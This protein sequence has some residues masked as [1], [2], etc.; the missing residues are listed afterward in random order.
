MK[1][2]SEMSWN[3]DGSDCSG[4]ALQLIPDEIPD[5]IKTL[6]FSFNFLPTLYNSTFQRLRNLVSLDLTR[7]SINF[8]YDDVFRYQFDLETLI[9]VANPLSFISDRAFSGPL[10]I[11]YLGLAGS[12]INS[13][14]DIPTDHL[15][16]LETLDLRGSDLH[17]L[18]G[19]LKL[20]RQQLKR[21][22]FDLNLIEN[23]RAADMETLRGTRDLEVSFKGNN[24]V[25]V[26][27][28]AFQNLDLGS[29][30]F[31]GCFDK[32]HISIL[33]KGLEGV[34][35]N[36]LHFG[37]FEDSSKG[38]IMPSDLQF[39]CNI[40][41]IDVSFQ[42]QYFPG[43]TN[44]SF[45]CFAEIQ[46]LDFTRAHLSR[47]PSNLSN[48]SML[49]HLILDMNSFTSV[50]D[51][52]PMN[53]PSLTHLSVSRN[54]EYLH[55][56]DNC[57]EPLS[58]LVELQLSHSNLMTGDVCCN[59]QL[60]GLR[61]LKLLNLSY[62]FLM[63]WE[64]LPFNATPNLE[65]LDC[66]KTQFLLSSSS[67]FIKLENLQTLNLSFTH[68]NLSRNAQLLKGLSKLRELHLRGN[69]IQGGVLAKTENFDYVP[70]LKNLDLSSCGIAQIRE[71]VFKNLAKLQYVDL[72][73]NQLAVLSLAAFY[74]LNQIQL[75]FGSNKIMVVDVNVVKDLGTSSSID[76]SSNPLAC[77]CTNYQF[78]MW[79]KDNVRKMK[80]VGKTVCDAT[81]ERIVDVDLKCV[82][83][84]RALGIVL[85]I[86]ITIALITVLGYFV[87][88]G[89]SQYRPY[90]RL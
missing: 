43:L 10:A 54:S 76:L 65:H 77:D 61:E 46:K 37:V 5:S 44:A 89:Q 71:D 8:I 35:T 49:S 52:N 15:D 60:A 38:Y 78:I 59:K 7:C 39:F 40:S 45:E 82:S 1:R 26:E 9:L 28:G 31:S 85:G 3:A 25:D 30:D 23:I 74:S 47:F 88:K 36:K 63:K 53:F 79:V 81:A 72:S 21:L 75:N 42:M 12:T 19:L 83:S 66:T 18:D 16:F 24:L 41:A 55:F 68:L 90:S 50:C 87:K 69:A 57:L 86:A 48:L 51:I 70:L 2:V 27:A 6:D 56:K 33:L 13:L 32:M 64:P 84:S 73:E 17:S 67:P 11:K 20:P 22:I 29:L 80:R 34:R 62:N 58:H 14:M 4:L